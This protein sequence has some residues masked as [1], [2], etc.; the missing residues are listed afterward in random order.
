ML[1]RDGQFETIVGLDVSHRAL[2]IAAD[3]L[4]L[5]RMSDRER[6]RVQLLHG[7]LTY[8]DQRLDGYDAAAIVEV[9]EHLDP[10]RLD[11]F[12]RA[13]F[14]SARPGTVVVTTPNAEYNAVW[15]TLPAGYVRHP[16]HR[17]E[18]TRAEFGAWA[19]DVAQR[20]GYQVDVQPI[21]PQ[22]ASLGAPTQMGIF[23]RG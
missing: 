11:A 16:D 12:A 1:L 9:I 23:R 18:W 15:L 6:A 17:F 5:D 22:D 2:E 3:R 4:H 8:R 7:S 10:P 14:G 13:V 19:A 20:F 21:G